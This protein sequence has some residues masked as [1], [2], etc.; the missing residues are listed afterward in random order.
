[1]SISVVTAGRE[2][3]DRVSHAVIAPGRT[4]RR[5]SRRTSCRTRV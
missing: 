2:S 4:R 3:D 1:M 5:R